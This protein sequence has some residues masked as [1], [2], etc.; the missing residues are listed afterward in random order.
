MFAKM[1]S[2]VVPLLAL[3]LLTSAFRPPE[4]APLPNL[5]KR[6]PQPVAANQKSAANSLRGNDSQV[7]VE[8]H[9]VTQG[10]AFVTARRGFLTD[11]DARSR[12]V[13]AAAWQA[14]AKN[15]PHRP[16]KAFLQQH[17]ALFG[18]GPEALDAATVARDFVTPHNRLRTVTWQQRVEG[19]A[20]FEGVFTAHTTEKGELVSV[21]SHFVSD[22]ARTAQVAKQNRGAR[23]TAADA[24]RLAA[25]NL[26]VALTPAELN[27]T[28]AAFGAEQKQAFTARGFVGECTAELVW[29]PMNKDELR[30]CWNVVLKPRARGETFRV[31]VDAASGDVLL[32]RCLTAYLTNSTYRVFTSDSRWG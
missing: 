26:S 8:F 5:D 14:I 17:R 30:L 27:S 7:A 32:R 31:L 6:S 28:A 12:T 3:A 4:L 9:P 19:V 1:I 29:F 23:L 22:A 20:V 10:A 16:A 24:L 2:R 11:A 21:A 15:D 18:H 25:E 13:S